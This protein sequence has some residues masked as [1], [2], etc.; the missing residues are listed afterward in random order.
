M[1]AAALTPVRVCMT[2]A[3]LSLTFC[4]S[5]AWPTPPHQTVKSLG[6]CSLRHKMVLLCTRRL[7]ASALLT[8]AGIFDDDDAT[9]CP[10]RSYLFPSFLLF[11]SAFPSGPLWPGQKRGSRFTVRT[12]L[13]RTFLEVGSK[14]GHELVMPMTNG[15]KQKMWPTCALVTHERVV[16]EWW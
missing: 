10:L 11:L 1:L 13:C 8:I 2:F 15:W 5:N 9:R 6:H 16:D 3:D 14:G 7:S 4:P 12:G